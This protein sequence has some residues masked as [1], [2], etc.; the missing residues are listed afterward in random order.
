MMIISFNVEQYQAMGTSSSSAQSAQEDEEAP[1]ADIAGMSVQLLTIPE[2]C[3]ALMRPRGIGPDKGN[4]LEVNAVALEELWSDALGPFRFSLIVFTR[5]S[6]GFIITRIGR[7][8]C[9]C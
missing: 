3:L 2:I 9:Q 4:L 1:P 7:W 5:C 6:R 8:S